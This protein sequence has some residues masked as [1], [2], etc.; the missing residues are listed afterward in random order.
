M[1]TIKT[2]TSIFSLVH[3]YDYVNTYKNHNAAQLIHENDPSHPVTTARG[4]L[5]DSLALSLSKNIDV[6]GMNVYRWDD[7]YN[8]FFLNGVQLVQNQCIYRKQ[9]VIAT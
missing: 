3:L 7:P 8:Y 9:E 5:P 6:W 1:G 4:E 2:E